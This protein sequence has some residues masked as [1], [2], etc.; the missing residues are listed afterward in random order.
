MKRFHKFLLAAVAIFLVAAHLSRAEEILV[1]RFDCEG[2]LARIAGNLSDSLK[3]NLGVLQIS[4]TPRSTWEGL[5]KK[6]NIRENDLDFDPGKLAS[7]L[8]SLGATGAVFGQVYKKE[9]M[10]VMSCS[11][12]AAGS[13][14]PIEFEPMLGAGVE[15][16]YDLTWNLA[17]I[18]SK[19]DK[20]KPEV[21]SV[22]PP[23]MATGIDQYAEIKVAFNEPMNPDSYGLAGD[24][25]DLFFTLDKVEYDPASYSFT[26][27]VH[28]YPEREYEFW[29]NGPGVKPFMDT[30]GNVARA[31][32]WSFTTK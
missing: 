7:L 11:Y 19:P 6:R 9:E 16:L 27:N 23:D 21:V 13:T 5:L 3:A 26:F 29:I 2:D 12:I 30:T 32:Q 15:D 17:V 4:T 20:I 28:L 10:L 1:V 8:P 14:T 22:T 31:Y 24:P 25:S 18:L